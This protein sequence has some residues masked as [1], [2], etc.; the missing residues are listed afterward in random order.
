[1][2]KFFLFI[3]ALFCCMMNVQLNAQ[4]TV[5]YESDGIHYVLVE[6]TYA[7]VT[8]RSA[9][10]VHPETTL[11]EEYV[12]PNPSS[13]TGAIVI[14]DTILYG[15]AGFPVKFINDSA[16]HQSTITSIDLPATITVFNSGAF[17]DCQTLQTIICRAQTP[18]STRIHS[19]PWDYADVF[20]S[21]D[22]DQ[23]SVYVPDGT[24]REYQ[25][26]GG[27]S[28][29]THYATIESIQGIESITDDPSLTT[30]KIL[31]NGILLIERD[32]KTFTALGTELRD[33]LK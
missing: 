18:P 1:M 14:P 11:E 16:F 31:R 5:L 6:S 25:E 4:S 33:A 3:A 27:W 28:E 30:G 26:T 7:Q 24:V 10:V 13:Y 9:Y 19:I 23:V 15:G 21:L 12:S 2:R 29:F 20:G 32:G 17:K 22:P 8:T